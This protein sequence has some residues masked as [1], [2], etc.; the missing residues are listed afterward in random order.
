VGVEDLCGSEEEEKEEKEE[1]EGEGWRR[2]GRK[3]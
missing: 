3:Q 1:K 2:G